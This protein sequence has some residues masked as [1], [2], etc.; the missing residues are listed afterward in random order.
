MVNNNK[1]APFIYNEKWTFGL[2][3]YLLNPEYVVLVES[4]FFLLGDKQKETLRSQLWKWLYERFGVYIEDFRFQPEE[5]TVET[6]EPLSAKRWAGQKNPLLI[7]LLLF[8][9]FYWTLLSS[10]VSH[11]VHVSCL[12]FSPPSLRFIIFLLFLAL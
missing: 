5:N 7:G 9:F 10:N 2:V 12:F 8:L 4:F 11:Y 1:T 3:W 6:E